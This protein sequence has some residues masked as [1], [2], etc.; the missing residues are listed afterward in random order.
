MPHPTDCV[1]LGSAIALLL[2]SACADADLRPAT[3]EDATSRRAELIEELRIDGHEHD[4]VPFDVQSS[5]AIA[6]G[7]DGSIAIN[8][9]QD[10]VVRFFSAD[11]ETRGEFGGEG[12]G[13]GEFERPVQLGWLEDSL[14]IYDAGLHRITLLTPQRDLA[15]TIPVKPGARPPPGSED[16]IPGA[17]FASVIGLRG[18]GALIAHVMPYWDRSPEGFRQHTFFAALDEAGTITRVLARIPSGEVS[19]MADGGSASIPFANRTVEAASRDGSMAAFARATI[20]IDAPSVAVH[21]FSDTGDTLFVRSYPIDLVPLPASVRD[22]VAD[23]FASRLTFSTSLA[24]A[25]RR[26]V[27]KITVHPPLQDLIVGRDGTVWIALAS[28][29]GER[30][31]LALAPEGEALGRVHLAERSRIAEA[32]RGRVWVIEK[33]EFDVESL[34]RYRVQW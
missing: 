14:W 34:V 15:R 31:Y 20:A 21:L 25:M 10:R 4:L 27:G 6:V 8:Q 33:D 2:L 26:E 32:E 19:V 12:A 28:R 9:M 30:P 24:D 1:T 23:R 16:R 22:S 3:A 17:E 5:G 11:G 13:P 18:G 7:R 29:N